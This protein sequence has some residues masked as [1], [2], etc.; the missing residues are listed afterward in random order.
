M[1]REVGPVRSLVAGFVLAVVVTASAPAAGDAIRP[2][3]TTV[4]LSSAKAGARP[5]TLTLELRYEMQCG[6]PGPGPLLIT[7]PP[8]ERL[9]LQL[10]AKS[11]LVDGHPTRHAARNGRVVSVALP[12]QHGVICDVIGP[13]VLKV[14]FTR[15]AGI[16]NPTGPGTYPLVA[17]TPRVS[18][19]ASM[20]IR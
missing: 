15:G 12:A 8:A 4:A 7:F 11:V 13:G 17:H 10:G 3:E 19:R 20:A 16:G 5:V 9:P 1:R 18:G 6:Q 2:A 14:V